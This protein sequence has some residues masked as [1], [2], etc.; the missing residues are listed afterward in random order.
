VRT[1]PS[2]HEMPTGARLVDG[3]IS[4]TVNHTYRGILDNDR[5]QATDGSGVGGPGVGLWVGARVARSEMRAR[6]FMRS[7]GGLAGER[8]MRARCCV[9]GLSFFSIVWGCRCRPLRRGIN[10]RPTAYVRTWKC[11]RLPRSA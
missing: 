1:N 6:S 5:K 4:V 11:D 10:P 3:R 2:A 8:V 9:S 7:K